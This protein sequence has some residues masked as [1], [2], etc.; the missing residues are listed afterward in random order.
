MPLKE[1]QY[2]LELLY[3]SDY[4]L[5]KEYKTIYSDCEELIKLLVSIVKTQKK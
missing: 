5:E 1:T 4:L 3:E 2:W